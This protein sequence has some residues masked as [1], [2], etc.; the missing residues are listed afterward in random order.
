MNTIGIKF[1]VSNYLIMKITWTVRTK[2]R[3]LSRYRVEIF[4]FLVLKRYLPNVITRKLDM[5]P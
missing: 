5:D 3:G 4:R 1:V 2:G